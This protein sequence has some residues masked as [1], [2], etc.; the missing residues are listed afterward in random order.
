MRVPRVRFTVRRMMVAVAIAALV[1]YFASSYPVASLIVVA[2][3]SL[4]FVILG[5]SSLFRRAGWG[6]VAAYY[7]VVLSVWVGGEAMLPGPA[8]TLPYLLAYALAGFGLIALAWVAQGRP[9]LLA[10][11]LAGFGLIALALVARHRAEL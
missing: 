6:R 5:L 1:S 2:Y 8:E 11:V 7:L 4:N 3:A 9:Y 10:Y